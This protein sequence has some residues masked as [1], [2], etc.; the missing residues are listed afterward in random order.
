[1]QN[2]TIVKI[3]SSLQCKTVR[4]GIHNKLENHFFPNWKQQKTHL[5]NSKASQKRKI[6]N[7]FRTIFQGVG[8]K[9]KKAGLKIIR[10]ILTNITVHRQAILLFSWNPDTEIEKSRGIQDKIFL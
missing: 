1:M 6:Q 7:S 3:S 2:D 5:T 10:I 8:Q 9:T 4:K